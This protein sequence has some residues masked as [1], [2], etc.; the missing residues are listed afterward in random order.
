[1][2]EININTRMRRALTALQT[3]CN[4]EDS[5]Q[6]GRDNF[7]AKNRFAMGVGVGTISAL[8]DL[9]LV[10]IGP[11][12]WTDEDGYRITESGRK[13]LQTKPPEK[14]RAPD[15]RLSPPR[16]RL[17]TLPHRLETRTPRKPDINED[18]E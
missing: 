14:T 2:M 10:E 3:E 8:I 15:T 5:Q 18:E 6:G 17:K 16:P 7:V 9:G 13:A 4:Y 12:R 11:N 1:M